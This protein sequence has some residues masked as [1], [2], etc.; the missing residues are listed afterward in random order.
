MT[1]YLAAIAAP[2]NTTLNTVNPGVI[3]TDMAEFGRTPVGAEQ[4]SSWQLLKRVGQPEDVAD[5]VTCL[6]GPGGRWVTG[7]HIDASGGTKI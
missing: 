6:A 5:I 2:R 3:E 1:E 7:H 4:A